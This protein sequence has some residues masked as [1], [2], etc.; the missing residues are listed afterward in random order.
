[1]LIPYGEQEVHPKG[2]GCSEEKNLNDNHDGATKKKG[3]KTESETHIL[4]QG[5]WTSSKVANIQ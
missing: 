4:S 3:R 1:M 2:M 5:P